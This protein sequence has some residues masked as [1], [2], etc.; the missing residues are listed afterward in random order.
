MIRTNCQIRTG[1][2]CRFH[3]GNNKANYGETTNY[4]NVKIN[5]RFPLTKS[6]LIKG[7][8]LDPDCVLNDLNWYQRM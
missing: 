4:G 5:N 8:Q 1:Y 7:N 3:I 6:N 2:T